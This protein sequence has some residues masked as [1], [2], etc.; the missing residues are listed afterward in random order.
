MDE[1]PY[2]LYINAGVRMT[3]IGETVTS[4]T[5][6]GETIKDDADYTIATIDYITDNDRYADIFSGN[7]NRED[8]VEM[9]RDYFGEY[10]KHIASENDGDI[11]GPLD[12]R[13]KI[14]ED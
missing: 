10:F 8:S 7:S 13:I 6:N 3:I 2:N 12:G 9:I 14:I 11:D 5:I 1:V 4:V